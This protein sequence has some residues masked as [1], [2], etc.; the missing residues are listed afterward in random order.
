MKQAEINGHFL[1]AEGFNS[2][3]ID[4]VDELFV[5]TR[6]KI[7]D[8]RIQF[9]DGDYI[10]SFEHLYFAF[11]NALKNFQT[12]KNISKDLEMETL[13]YASGQHQIKKAIDLFGVKPTSSR[14]IVL[15]I[16][17]SLIKATR[18]LGIIEKILRGKRSGCIINLTKNKIAKIKVAFEIGEK[19]I[20][21][22]SEH[23]E[24]ESIILL[25]IERIA[26]LATQK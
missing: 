13:L 14:V 4:D 21:A 22:T 25:V 10:A 1:I 2:V 16:S 19:E 11:L 18:S 12:G 3:K 23:S 20:Q 5:E 15:I 17:N 8:C 9:F 7:K 24:K 26:L 6:K